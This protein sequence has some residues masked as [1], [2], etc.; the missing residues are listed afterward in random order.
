MIKKYM[1]ENNNV[2]DGGKKEGNVERENISILY[3][4]LTDDTFISMAKSSFYV[5]EAVT[6]ERKKFTALKNDKMEKAT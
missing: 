3:V 5:L 4:C 2:Q 6:S 1:M